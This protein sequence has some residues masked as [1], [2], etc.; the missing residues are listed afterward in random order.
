MAT[1]LKIKKGDN[2]KVIS[3]D[4]KGKTGRVLEVYPKDMRVLVEDVNIRT[5]HIKPS[6]KD[7]QGGRK[8]KALPIHYSNVMLLD[9]EGNT[10]R[11]G[12]INK[13]NK[14]GFSTKT[15]IAKTNGSEI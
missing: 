8:T 11:V 3:G 14:S 10:T 9:S 1:K 12:F 5:V 2:V 6:Q 7:Q 13:E 15:R 4:D